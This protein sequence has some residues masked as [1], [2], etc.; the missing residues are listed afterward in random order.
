MT[1]GG[2]DVN[3]P[4]TETS[5]GVAYLLGLPAGSIPWRL[6]GMTLFSA[7]VVIGACLCGKKAD[8][9]WSFFLAV[10]LFFPVAVLLVIR[11]TIYYFRYLVV[12]Y[13]FFCLLL[14][15]IL[16]KLC[17]SGRK[18]PYAAI[19]VLAF[20]LVGQTQYLLPLFRHG[21]GNYR[22]ILA[23]ISRTSHGNV[24]NV[25]SDHDFRNKMLLSFYGRFLPP[26]QSVHYIEQN[27]WNLEPP[28]WIILHSL[29]PSQRPDPFIGIPGQRIYRLVKKEESAGN[30][31]FSW[32]L[33]HLTGPGL[34]SGHRP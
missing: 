21:R 26:R 19:V 33:Y 17:R 5:R 4:F 16:G 32:F 2:G 31:G 18:G 22:T 11:P 25:G 6:A 24:L 7:V 34:A 12:T 29:D 3:D 8:H 10:L 9:A 13:P 27:R 23:E 30:S 28:E 1:I 15:F 20:Y 14:S